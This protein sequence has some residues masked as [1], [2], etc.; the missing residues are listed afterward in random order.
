MKKVMFGED[1]KYDITED[2]ELYCKYKKSNFILIEIPET[3][4]GEPK[5]RKL[6]TAITNFSGFVYD[7]DYREIILSNIFYDLLVEFADRYY[8][9]YKTVE[10]MLTQQYLIYIKEIFQIKTKPN[11]NFFGHPT[12]I[13]N[14]KFMEKL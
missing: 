6:K 2:F 10:M 9:K 11:S 7:N 5:C 1:E 3:I 4:P 12:I 13:I 14:Y 8:Q